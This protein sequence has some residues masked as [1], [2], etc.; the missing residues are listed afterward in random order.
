MTD[1]T[2]RFAFVG[3]VVAL[4]ALSCPAYAD[5]T[6]RSADGTVQLTVPNGWREGKPTA[7]NVKIQAASGRGGLV[8]VRVVTKEDF[9]DLKSFAN[10]GLERLKRNM[11]DAEPKTEDIQINNKP[12]IRIIMEGTQANGQR[13]GFLLT[14]FEADGNFIDVVAMANASAFKSE[15]AVFA[16]LASQVK[17]LADAAASPPAQAAVPATPAAGAKPPAARSP[18]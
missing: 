10:V 13:R 1:K 18:R 8:L 4:A 7:P 6:I 17:L 11:P 15:E 2:T 14:F 9:K 3:A 12:A 5:M 16:G